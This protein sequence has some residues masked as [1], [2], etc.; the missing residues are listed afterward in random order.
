MSAR[1]RGFVI[2]IVVVGLVSFF[3]WASL[4]K[5]GSAEGPEVRVEELKQD[6]IE[7]WVSAPGRIEPERD[8]HISSNVQG[9]IARVEV[10]E[11]DRVESG[12]LLVQL[13]DERYTS[14]VVQTRSRLDAALANLAVTEAQL[15]QAD[16]DLDRKQRLFQQDLISPQ[17]IED[18][19]TTARVER[20]RRNAAREEVG[21]VRAQLEQAQKDLKETVFRA[22]I[23][24]IVTA[25]NVEVGENVVTGTMNNPGTVIVTLSELDVMQ[26]KA[27]VDETDVVRITPGQTAKV[28]VDALEDVPMGGEVITVGQSGRRTSSAAQS[29]HFT[30]EVRISD[31]PSTLR[32]GMS[33]D[34]EILS[35]RREEAWVV[36]IQALAA[37]PASRVL[38]WRQEEQA[39]K[40]LRSGGGARPLLD[41][42]IDDDTTREGVFVLK[43]GIARFRSVNLGLRSESR[44]EVVDAEEAGLVDGDLIITGP[45]RV[46]RALR[47][48]EPVQQAK[49]KKILR[50][51]RG[52]GGP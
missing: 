50:P 41:S 48:G 24:G 9:R 11:G 8:V 17:G 40:T 5:G 45:Y 43:D 22:P 27:E 30:V 6:S 37:H 35:G 3:I 18:A 32:P 4:K 12:D 39:G 16:Q 28:L 25:L 42:E 29:T 26:V 2:G 47:G 7:S 36:P 23:D 51:G 14:Q 10:I 13:D 34:V 46:L 19:S 31:P 15:T 52:G 33:A 21:S 38:H 44:I 49:E 20:A 1:T